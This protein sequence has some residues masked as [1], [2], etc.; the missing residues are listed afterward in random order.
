MVSPVARATAPA[1][2]PP[3]SGPPPGST[4]LIMG[5]EYSRVAGGCQERPAAPA[6]APPAL[7]RGGGCVIIQ[8]VFV[9][10]QGK[11]GTRAHS[12]FHI[13]CTPNGPAE[14][15]AA[16]GYVGGSGAS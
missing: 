13:V 2:P 16:E 15:A 11:S 9:E 3:A 10:A 4:V 6:A 1:R 12:F 5:S 8:T 7:R 14:T